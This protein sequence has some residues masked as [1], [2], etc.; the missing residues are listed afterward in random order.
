LGR[1]FRAETGYTLGDFVE[2]GMVQ[3]AHSMLAGTTLPLGEIARQLGFATSSSF[4]NAFQRATGLKPR[5]VERVAV[6]A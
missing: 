4:S 2:A 3:H 6:R 1:A 5:E